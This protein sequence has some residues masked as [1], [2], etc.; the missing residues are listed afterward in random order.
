MILNIGYDEKYVEE[1]INTKFLGL[2][3]DNHLNW[4]NYID[5]MIPKLSTACY[6]I[7]LMSHISST[8]TFKSIYFAYFHSTVKYGIV[9]W[10]NSPNNKIFTLQKRTVKIITGV[11]S[12]YSCRNLFMRID[13]SPLPC[14]YIFSLMNSVI[15]NQ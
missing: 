2:Q 14:K 10:G 6:T 15:N 4:E 13:I 9:F 11:K 8:D 5:L 12:K 7:R 1:S 3:T